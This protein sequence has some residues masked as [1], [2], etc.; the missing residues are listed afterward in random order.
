[1]PKFVFDAERLK[2]AVG[3]AKSVKPE[4][5]DF[6]F[7]F[8]AASLSM[9]SYSKRSYV[10]VVV[11]FSAV[12][13][14]PT[15]YLSDEFYIS[16]DRIAVFD[17]ELETVHV[18]VGDKSMT[19]KVEGGG[20]SRSASLK[21]RAVRSRRPPVPGLLSVPVLFEI[22]SSKLDVLL[23]QASCSASVKETK[24]EDDMR[25]NQV[26]FYSDS[27][28]AVSVSRFSGTFV[29][30]DSLALDLSIVSSDLPE[31][32]RFCSK[33]VS[34]VV[35]IHQDADR[36]YVRDPSSGSFMA[37]SRVAMKKPPYQAMPASGF[38]ESIV[39][40][41]S[42]LNKCLSW[43]SLTLDGTQRVSF[44]FSRTTGSGGELELKNGSDE[45]SKLQCQYE[46]GDGFRA[47][48]PVKHF[49]SILSY[50]DD[51][52]RVEYGHPDMSSLACLSPA[53]DLSAPDVRA[54]HY[55]LSM[56]KR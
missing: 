21:P 15:D 20:S 26:H 38:S 12:P 37:F 48:F 9:F 42:S 30:L 55:L 3:M 6:C 47:D 7:K 45:I 32:R 51:S 23:H 10:L 18:N 25:V 29:G 22:D 41:K 8:S 19:I 43:A 39:I 46:Q 53:V 14:V 56:V 24:T 16:E 35:S 54:R 11:P 13:D 27:R 40:E 52:V 49:L 36:L 2:R 44:N 33:C 50:M 1:M 34:D 28:C 31:I 17:T 5:G 4:T